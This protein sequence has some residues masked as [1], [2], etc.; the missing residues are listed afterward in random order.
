MWGNQRLNSLRFGPS[1]FR[2]FCVVILLV[3]AL[4]GGGPGLAVSLFSGLGCE[5][6]TEAAAGE[7]EIRITSP[8]RHRL[9]FLRPKVCQFDQTA[10]MAVPISRP[11]VSGSFR[12]LVFHACGAGINLQC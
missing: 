9:R 11:S 4:L 6:C 7:F 1:L 5:E 3:C 10:P 2:S 8:Q 12:V